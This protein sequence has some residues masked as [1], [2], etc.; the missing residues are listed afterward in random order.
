[1]FEHPHLAGHAQLRQLLRKGVGAHH[2]GQL[3]LWKLALETLMTEGLL[4]AIF[5]TSTVSAGVNFPARSVVFFHSDRFN[6]RT[7]SPLTPT[8]FHQMIGRAGRRG[9]DHIGFAITVPGKFMDVRLIAQ[10]VAS[11][12]LD[13][14]SQIRINFSMVLNLLLSYTPGQI[15]RLLE[16]SFAA[17]TMGRK[18]PVLAYHFQR[19]LRFLQQVEYATPDG[20]LTEIGRWASQLR[21][22]Q[23]LMIAEALRRRVMPE[24][25]PAALAAIMAAFVYDREADE[26]LREGLMPRALE[27]TLVTAQRS[28]QPFALLLQQR[29][30][31]SRPLLVRP[32]WTM[33]AWAAGEPWMYV[34]RQ[35]GI[36][37][38][39][40][41]M[42][43]SRT[44]D[45]LRH[46]CA[47]EHEFPQVAKTAAEAIELIM[48]EPVVVAYE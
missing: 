5:A 39:D 1:M 23:P 14:L 34:V 38:G 32:A 3:P 33:Y 25:D 17:H 15:E 40:L 4:D 13:V 19:H 11:P 36:A 7:F 47:L 10:L 27:Q 30:F 48:R 22:D 16:R 20:R 12:P 24:R 9:K 45:H 31:E 29:G 46:L 44:T 2:G 6:G 18:Q 42:L 8:E 43:V 35:S 41:A 26:P 21:V 37:A 28:L